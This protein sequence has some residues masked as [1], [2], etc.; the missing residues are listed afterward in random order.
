MKTAESMKTAR[1]AVVDP[2]K[3]ST[4]YQVLYVG[5]PKYEASQSEK[6]GLRQTLRMFQETQ[7]CNR[8]IV[9]IQPSFALGVFIVWTKTELAAIDL[10]QSCGEYERNYGVVKLAL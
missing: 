9:K 7:T 10:P 5:P 6:E 2:N 4:A 1:P 8:E 3:I